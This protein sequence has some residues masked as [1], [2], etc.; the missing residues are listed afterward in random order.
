MDEKRGYVVE[1]TRTSV[2]PLSGIKHVCATGM[3]RDRRTQRSS[4]SG[5]ICVVAF[6]VV[7]CH[8]S[9]TM[10]IRCTHANSCMAVTARVVKALLSNGGFLNPSGSLV[11]SES[12]F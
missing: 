11:E 10:E 7:F 4:T 5:Q 9:N 12:R 1:G 6:E 8:W 2:G 3:K